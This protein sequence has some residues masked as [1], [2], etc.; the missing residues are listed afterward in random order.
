MQIVDG[1]GI[2]GHV[3]ASYAREDTHRVDRLHGILEENGIPVW[4]DT[5]SLWPGEDWHATIRQAITDDTLA[6]LACFSTASLART[7]SY[8]N[9]ELV[10]A[11]E[12]FRRRPAD[13]PWLIPIRFDECEIPALDLG[14][15]RTLRSIQ[16]ADIFDD[17]FAEG[18]G[19]V[20]TA[21]RRILG[22]ALGKVPDSAAFWEV[23]PGPPPYPVR[24]LSWLRQKKDETHAILTD[25]PHARR[26]QAEAF[27]PRLR[28]AQFKTT[29]L[30]PGYRG[31]EI[32]A[33]LCEIAAELERVVHDNAEL[34]TALIGVRNGR[35]PAV[36]NSSRQRWGFP[37]PGD[38]RNKIFTIT[39]LRPGYDE[40]EV[41]DLLDEAEAELSW[42]LDECQALRAALY[43]IETLGA[44]D[45]QS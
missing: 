45:A 18:A 28:G 12:E 20:V 1:P 7:S 25:A 27:I 11:I 24:E 37:T 33:F 17:R 22:P 42:L 23:D 16:R 14:A 19:R 38:I 3:F 4:R 5:V 35:E 29:R 9:E 39:R 21:V 43:E 41:D 26:A 32:D 34:R 15:G 13:R 30:R 6:F 31:K 8:Q 40:D 44:L 36:S 10:L 2:D